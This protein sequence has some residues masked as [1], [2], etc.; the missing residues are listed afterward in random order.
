MPT[1]AFRCRDCGRRFELTFASIAA[2][3]QAEPACPHCHSRDL[4]RI[5]T[6]VALPRTEHDYTRMS[7]DEMLSVL[8][9]GDRGAVDTMFRQVEET[10]GGSLRPAGPPPADED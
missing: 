9:S 2:Y 5:I 3:A 4:A 6:D 1:Y 10:A 8:N 7:S